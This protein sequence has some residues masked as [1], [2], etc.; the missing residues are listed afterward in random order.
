MIPPEA[1][2]GFPEEREVPP[3]SLPPAPQ[4]PTPDTVKSFGLETCAIVIEREENVLE[5]LRT[6][7]P[8]DVSFKTTSGSQAQADLKKTVS[9]S[10]SFLTHFPAVSKHCV[11][12]DQEDSISVSTK[13]IQRDIYQALKDL[14][15]EL[16]LETETLSGD[17]QAGK[18]AAD[19]KKSPSVC[20]KGPGKAA[21]ALPPAPSTTVPSVPR[22][23]PTV[24]SAPEL[25]TTSTSPLSVYDFSAIKPD[26][27]PIPLQK[28]RK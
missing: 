12:G 10:Q 24:P 27:P 2:R 28:A 13:T 18:K 4:A 15:K 22:Y 7:R 11:S 25:P 14:D 6:I 9:P 1:P 5:E 19:S 21:P 16:N 8:E 20:V 23:L 26:T 3:T 17:Q